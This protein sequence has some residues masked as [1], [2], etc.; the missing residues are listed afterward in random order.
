LQSGDAAFKD[1]L[2]SVVDTDVWQQAKEAAGKTISTL[3]AQLRTKEDRAQQFASD[4]ATAQQR[5]QELQRQQAV[6]A[7]ENQQQQVRANHKLVAWSHVS[8]CVSADHCLV[9]VFVSPSGLTWFLAVVLNLGTCHV[10]CVTCHVSYD[11]QYRLAFEVQCSQPTVKCIVQA[12]VQQRERS[13]HRQVFAAADSIAVLHQELAAAAAQA[14]AQQQQLEAAKTAAH[15]AAKAAEAAAAAEHAALEAQR[16][17]QMQQQLQQQQQIQAVDTAQQQQ[18]QQQ[19][20]FVEFDESA[21]EMQLQ[22]LLLAEH[23][24]AQQRSQQQGVTQELNGQLTALV[25]RRRKYLSIQG[26]V[27]NGNGDGNES[28]AVATAAAVAAIVP[29][30]AAAAAGGGGGSSSPVHG[31]LAPVCEQCLQPINLDLYQR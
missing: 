8:R 1:L 2:S 29:A 16:Q 11:Q 20:Q 3:Q 31:G 27:S 22:P 4:L 25:T 7:Q 17:A 9:C 14:A 15:A 18:Q 10:S 21:A 5:L 26:V 24:L 23:Q 6:W 28:V 12:E 13:A 30:A 19:Q